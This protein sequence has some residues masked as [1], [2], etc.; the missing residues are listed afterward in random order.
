VCVKSE[1]DQRTRFLCDVHAYF[2]Y[3]SENRHGSPSHSRVVKSDSMDLDGSPRSLRA[4]VRLSKLV[5]YE[6]FRLWEPRGP[7]MT[8]L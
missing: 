4:F 5:P 1:R 8:V 2:L 7:S 6:I 3:L